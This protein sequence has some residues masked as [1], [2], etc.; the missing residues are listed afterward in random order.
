MTCPLCGSKGW[1]G[2]FKFQCERTGCVNYVAPALSFNVP[3]TWD[4]P[5]LYYYIIAPDGYP[6]GPIK[7]A[8]QLGE[9]FYKHKTSHFMTKDKKDAVPKWAGVTAV[10]VGGFAS[11]QDCE[12]AWNNGTFR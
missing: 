12:E 7:E 2:L 4:K 3:K 11:D 10:K 5:G 8:P 9:V 1:E 6:Y